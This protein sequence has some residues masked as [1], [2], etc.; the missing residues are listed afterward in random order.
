MEFLLHIDRQLFLAINH[1]P[2]TGALNLLALF[3]SG[4]GTAGIVWFILAVVLFLREERKDHLFF[5]PVVAAGS[6][7][8]LMVELLLKPLIGRLRPDALMGAIIVG[9]P[10]D[11]FSLPSGHATIAW[12]MAV[13]L[14]HKE[15]KVQW[16]LYGLA[17]LIS[18]SRIFLGK[19]FPLDVV[20]GAGIGWGIGVVSILLSHKIIS[21]IRTQ[22]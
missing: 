13:V 7:S 15:P 9:S 3:L 19:H 11:G 6:G 20:T 17:M 14:A 1:L 12:A 22:K 4:V 2:H 18:L 10:S 16:L 21:T 8:W 5:L